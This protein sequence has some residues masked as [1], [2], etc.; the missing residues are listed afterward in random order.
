MQNAFGA[1]LFLGLASAAMLAAGFAACGGSDDN[2]D[3]TDVPD[4]AEAAPAFDAGQD[5]GKPDTGTPDTGPVYDAGTPTTLD[6]GDLYE[7]G[8]P[9]VLGGQLE[10]EPNDD[11][12]TANTLAPTR[13]GVV[14]VNADGGADASVAELDYV[15]FELEAG[16]KTYYLDY[17]GNVK[18]DVEVDG[19][20]PVTV[21]P[22]ASLPFVVGQPTYVKVYSAD[23]KRQNWR[24][25]LFKN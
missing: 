3:V 23:G 21:T 13:C 10:E 6:G 2:D 24:V 16:T 22:T 5:T 18:L 25:T 19:S 7:G 15:K 12:A 14:F 8:V 9:C 1:R 11:Q 4:A 17:Q 20:A